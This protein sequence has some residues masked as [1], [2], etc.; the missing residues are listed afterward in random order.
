[1][2]IVERE[3]YRL[4][5]AHRLQRFDDGGAEPARFAGDRGERCRRRRGDAGRVEQAATTE[6]H[7]AAHVLMVVGGDGARRDAH[8]AIER[9]ARHDFFDEAGLAAARRRFD[10][11]KR[12]ASRA[13]LAPGREDCGKLTFASQERDAT[14][15]DALVRGA[16]RGRQLPF[17]GPAQSI[18]ERP[19]RGLD[20]GP[21]LRR[22][23][24]KPGVQLERR[25]PVARQR[26]PAQQR[27]Q[28]ALGFRIEVQ[29]ASSRIIG[30]EQIAG[31]EPLLGMLNED[32]HLPAVPVPLLGVQPVFERRRSIEPESIREFSSDERGGPGPITA[33]DQAVE[34]VRVQLDRARRQL[35]LVGL[36]AQSLLADVAPQQA[37]RLAQRLKGS[38]L[39]LVGP[40]QADRLVARAAARGRASDVQEQRDIVAPEQLRGRR[41]PVHGHL[42]RAERADADHR[43]RPSSHCSAAIRCRAVSARARYSGSPSLHQRTTA[44]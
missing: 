37:N 3:Q 26:E 16:R 13:N 23:F 12:E 2:R 41:L 44:R 11:H 20:L 40:E 7:D 31:V 36:S 35:E 15:R 25:R 32:V 28:R 21:G 42:E 5:G 34:Q 27:A 19:S 38:G 24:L 14:P 30:A 43:G 33:F 39:R 10:H 4:L 1:M 9:G 17:A 22:A 29:R 8:A 6:C 18:D